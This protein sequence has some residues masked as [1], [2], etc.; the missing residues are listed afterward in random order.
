MPKARNLNNPTRNEVP[1]GES[2]HP[3]QTGV[4]KARNKNQKT[5]YSP[6]TMSYTSSYYHVVFRSYRSEQAIPVEH[7]RELYAF[8]FGIARNLRCKT[9]RI[10]GMPD[11]VH[12]F[13]SLPPTL[14]IASFVQRVKTDWFRR[15]SHHQRV[16]GRIHFF[17]NII[18]QNN[19]RNKFVPLPFQ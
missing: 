5:K 12:L 17:T 14:S 18:R 15:T 19:I 4:P 11:H 2:G 8:M 9:L 13:V 1:C 10:G 3:V 7:E 16:A 6:K